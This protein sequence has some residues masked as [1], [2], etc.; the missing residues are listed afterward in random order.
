MSISISKQ[1][2]FILTFRAYTYILFWGTKLFNLAVSTT[3]AVVPDGLLCP[4]IPVN[5]K[6]DD[7]R[8]K[9]TVLMAKGY[10]NSKETT[11]DVTNA[12]QLFLNLYWDHEA[13]DDKGG[14]QM[15][16]LKEIMNSSKHLTILWICYMFGAD[17]NPRAPPEVSVPKMKYL[18][19]D[20]IT[21]T[22]YKYGVH[23]IPGILATEPIEV[24]FDQVA[25]DPKFEW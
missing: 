12:F 2:L 21:D 16:K 6:K 11:Y 20:L 5:Y 4:S 18:F 10:S 15:H 24:M 17:N 8:K 14:I 22:V 3:V 7:D 23:S 13:C 19:I 1:Q 9:I 25:M